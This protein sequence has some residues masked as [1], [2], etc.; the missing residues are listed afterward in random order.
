VIRPP[1]LVANSSRD[2]L[3]VL[4]SAEFARQLDALVSRMALEKASDW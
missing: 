4:D 1:S 3:N 2:E